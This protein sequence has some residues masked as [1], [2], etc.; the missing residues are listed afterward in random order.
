MDE[1]Q[2]AFL[3]HEDV[4]LSTISTAS[5]TDPDRIRARLRAAGGQ[6]AFVLYTC[7]RAEYYIRGPPHIL[8][9]VLGEFGVPFEDARRASGMEVARHAIR[10]AS[11]L[12]SV[13]LGENEVLGQFSD[14]A[15][16]AAT[17]VDGTLS[18][19][20]EKAIRTGK[21]VRSETQINNGHTSLGTAAVEFARQRLS[22]PSEATALV[23]GTGDIGQ[24][25]SKSLTE[26][27]MEVYL[28]N[29]T[30]DSARNWAKEIEASAI[31]VGDIARYLPRADL[32]VT[33][34]DAPHTIL[35]RSDF[36]N[37]DPVAVDLATPPDIDQNVPITRFDTTDVE[38]V[39]EDS[40]QLRVDATEAAESI[41]ES[42]LDH[43]KELLK[44]QY[45]DQMLSRIYER[46]EEIRTKEV[47][48][49][50]GAGQKRKVDE[51]TLEACTTSIVNQLLATPTQS[52]KE[53]AVA[54]DYK[55]LAAVA[56][57]FEIDEFVP[58]DIPSDQMSEAITQDT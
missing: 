10:V 8:D 32:I 46:A 18:V 3:T 33:A 53:A 57:V 41:V 37:A 27:D 15:E 51:D 11:G 28:A 54:E 55:T 44:R 58:E 26:H 47:D 9:N 39:V 29:R 22:S 50:V 17:D 34:T 2:G 7:N 42:E 30:Y 1:L 14:A 16:R 36:V 43:L 24:I 23:V 25:V 52:M 19:V 5:R 6:E 4:P 56:E 49:A 13:V 45:A 21:R 31:R 48:E 35:E 38:S 40:K 20:L 12:E